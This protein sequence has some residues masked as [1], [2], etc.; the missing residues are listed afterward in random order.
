VS[1]AEFLAVALGLLVAVVAVR[2]P[3]IAWA[4][5]AAV[6]AFGLWV[7]TVRNGSVAGF[8]PMAADDAVAA[9][10]AAA[11]ASAARALWVT[12]TVAAA[13]LAVDAVATA[14]G[15]PT[16][17]PGVPSPPG[18][19]MT[20]V[21]GGLLWF[22]APLVPPLIGIAGPVLAVALAVRRHPE[23]RLVRGA[24][25][26]ILL[27][28][29]AALAAAD[30]TLFERL[31]FASATDVRRLDLLVATRGALVAYALVAALHAAWL[32]RRAGGSTRT[33]LGIGAALAV[34][35]GVERAST[36][37]ATAFGPPVELAS[38]HASLPAV[39]PGPTSRPRGGCLV[40]P[41]EGGGWTGVTVGH[42]ARS[43]GTIACPEA[44]A[45][46]TFP[47]DAVPL[48]AL[49]A[50]APVGE[51]LGWHRGGAGQIVLLTRVGGGIAMPAWR[52]GARRIEAWAAPGAPRA[53]PLPGSVLLSRDQDG[54][55]L[56]YA[57]GNEAPADSPGR[58]AR[59]A[60]AGQVRAEVLIHP[61]A[62]PTVADLVSL[63]DEA[64]PDPRAGVRCVLVGGDP[65]AWRAALS[66]RAGTPGVDDGPPPEVIYDDAPPV[67]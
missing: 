53:R 57:R 26:T 45:P 19:W 15:A 42:P 54:F 17:G 12:A 40:R 49:P 56:L 37:R 46:S 23:P 25:G 21:L 35:I 22:F 11:H 43:R 63:C 10:A 29:L 6:L 16:E 36:A 7:A 67:E 61:S 24:A 47:G 18:V 48:L 33:V 64:A 62:A 59:Q 30:E 9:L 34:A 39:R 28:G 14:R 51:A 50:S 20:P 44:V 2:R 13:L 4:G 38:V 65:E 52:V 5:A 55:T 8:A 3:W 31:R 60:L 58:A 32:H 1:P 27:V 66:S 41:T